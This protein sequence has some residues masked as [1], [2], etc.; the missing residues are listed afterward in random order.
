MAGAAT[1]EQLL[2]EEIRQ[3]RQEGRDIDE[4]EWRERIASCGGDKSK[5]LSVYS[6]TASLPVRG[7][8]GYYE[9]TEPEEIRR[10]SG[11]PADEPFEPCGAE[12]FRGAW[13]GRCI[14]CALGQPVEGWSSPD[15]VKWYEDA[16]KYPIKYFVPTVSGGKRNERLTTDEK[17]D[18]MPFDDDTR[19]TVINYLLMKEKGFDFDTWDV[20]QHWTYKLAFRHVFTA[21]SQGYLNFIN[22]DECGHWSK[23]ENACEVMK[24]NGVSTYLNPYREWIGAQIRADAFGYIAAGRPKLAAK[25]AWRDAA[26]THVKNGVYGE[27]FFAA[28]IAAAF[29]YKDLQKCFDTA[30]SAVPKKSRFYETALHARELAVSDIS[31]E[32]LR[33]VLFEEGKKYSWVHTLNNAAYCIAAMFR[34]PADF[35]EAVVFVVEC[36]MDADCNGAT[37]G[38]CMGALLGDGAIPDDLKGAMKNRFSVQVSPYDDYPID[39][40]ADECKEL[41]DKLGKEE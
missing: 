8:F 9:P 6:E 34:Y 40:F 5:L 28:F 33:D 10:E 21:E 29:R 36:G 41:C 31:R 23:P 22:Q 1:L 18:G 17:I 19:F 3:L 24:R 27:M 35:R 14:G 37:V 2:Y 32:K 7:D 4:N 26:F 11:M 38:S 39:R 20:A 12:Y 30:L 13:L 15:I 25:L 16:G